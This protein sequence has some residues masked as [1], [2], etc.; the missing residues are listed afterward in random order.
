MR[1]RTI[2]VFVVS[3]F[4]T[5]CNS[6]AYNE[7]ARIYV[8]EAQQVLKDEQWCSKR[9]SCSANDLVKFEAGR[10]QLGPIKHG[11][12]YINVYQVDDSSVSGKII[13]RVREKQKGMP[14][15]S[16]HVKVYASKHNE[17]KRLTAEAKIG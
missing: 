15:V 3:I 5:G 1:Q 7:E 11:G 14:G 4:L 10:W 12:V 8:L 9:A 6:Q 13:A 2:L 17:P 16:V